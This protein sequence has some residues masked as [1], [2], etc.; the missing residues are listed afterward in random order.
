M[1]ARTVLLESTVAQAQPRA[2]I[3][4][5]GRQPTKLVQLCAHLVQRA[6]LPQSPGL[7][8]AATVLL[9]CS[10]VQLLLRVPIA[11]LVVLPILLEPPSAL[12]VWLA[13]SNPF[14]ARLLVSRAD[15]R[16]LRLQVEPLPVLLVQRERQHLLHLLHASPL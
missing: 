12:S 7:L 16:R 10:R 3:A 2:P 6:P 9:V 8:S 4:L 15:G 5:Q 1:Y 14:Q 13:I 11:L